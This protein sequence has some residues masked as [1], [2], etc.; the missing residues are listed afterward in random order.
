VLLKLEVSKKKLEQ[1]QQ[2][3]SE[4]YQKYRELKEMEQQG[5]DVENQLFSVLENIFGNL[6]ELK[7][8]IE[9]ITHEDSGKSLQDF[10][11]KLNTILAHSEEIKNGQQPLVLR[12]FLDDFSGI[13][14][15]SDLY[16][17]LMENLESLTSGDTIDVR[18]GV[19]KERYDIGDPFEMRFQ[20]NK[21]VYIILMHISADGSITFLAPNRLVPDTRIEGGRIY[22][23][24]HDFGMKL[25]VELPYGID[26]INLFCSTEKID[27]FEADFEKESF[28]TVHPD[29][30]ERLKKLLNSL[31][32]L[33][34]YEWSGNSVLIRIGPT[35]R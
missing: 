32:Q 3:L 21:D 5:E 29:D 11:S 18:M 13:I 23:T 22:S 25:R 20:V 12:E 1:L 2:T 30:E 7:T 9:A 27:L 15:K 10:I 26:T 33:K 6:E 16:Q 31:D 8:V 19:E 17:Q 35:K 4:D 34:N 14:P 28:Y 24:L